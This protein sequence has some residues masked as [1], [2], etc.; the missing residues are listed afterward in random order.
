MVFLDDE[1]MSTETYEKISKV[2]NSFTS[3]HGVERTLN[4]LGSNKSHLTY[5]YTSIHNGSFYV[6]MQ[7]LDT[8]SIGLLDPDDEGT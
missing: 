7:R 4:K 5:S 3:R 1:K 2:F 8:D 6:P